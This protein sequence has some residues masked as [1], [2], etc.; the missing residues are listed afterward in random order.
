[1]ATDLDTLTVPA[2]PH[3]QGSEYFDAVNAWPDASS[4]IFVAVN[5]LGPVANYQA[6]Y[7]PETGTTWM[8]VLPEPGAG[9]SPWS[10]AYPPPP[11]P[12]EPEGE[13]S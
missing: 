9:W 10:Q 4:R 2:N 11:P 12:P 5:R 6:G 3:D 8:R 1:M 7:D 13:K